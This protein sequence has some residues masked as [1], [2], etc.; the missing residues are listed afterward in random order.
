MLLNIIQLAF[1]YQDPNFLHCEY[2]YWVNIYV[3]IIGAL[4]ATIWC[5][6]GRSGGSERS[7]SEGGVGD[8]PPTITLSI[9]RFAVGSDVDTTDTGVETGSAPEGGILEK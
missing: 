9:P 1:A 7:K 2:I 6:S 8:G 5:S 4:L 3:T